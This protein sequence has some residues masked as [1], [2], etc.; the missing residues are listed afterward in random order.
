MLATRQKVLRR[1]WYPV[2]PDAALTA[3]KPVPFRLLGQD[4]VLWRGKGGAPAA[5]A[6][7]CPHRGA[8][9][10]TGFLDRDVPEGPAL[11]CGYHGW[12]Y[13]ADGRCVKV[14]Q[15]H[16][17]LRG[18]KGG[19][20][21]HHA[22]S[23]YGW[24]WVCLEEPLAT[25]PEIPEAADPAFRRIDE[26]HEPW[27]VSGLRIMENSFDTAHF[28]YVHA[29]T[30][31]I[32]EDPKPAP[33]TIE[34]TDWGF[35]MRSEAPVSNRG[36]SKELVKSD[37]DRTVRVIEG[38]WFLPFFRASRIDYPTGLTHILCTGATPIDDRHSMICQ[39]V[40]RNDTEAEAPA[41]K[42]IAFDRAVTEEDRGVLETTTYD[43]PLEMGAE[44][45]MPADR[46][47]IEMRRRLSALLA[48]H[49][50]VEARLP[51]MA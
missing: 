32:P 2:M 27:A 21:A 15:A 43:V 36:I 42:V 48:E 49:D 33:S 1:F 22:A 41:A 4:I 16:D 23:R 6:D 10:S 26:F 38:R 30:F 13:G 28:S 20:K 39:W 25:I 37:S 7:R 44:L 11:A 40:L 14:P 45:H 9:L 17:P 8:K 35:I 50:E 19:A 5:L 29:A 31:G 34:H 18:L 24:I 51:E 47:G 46:P 3:D 12:A